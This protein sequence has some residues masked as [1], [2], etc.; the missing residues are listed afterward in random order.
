MIYFS[1]VTSSF[2]KSLKDE[3]AVFAPDARII[4]EWVNSILFESV[5]DSLV[6]KF[7][8]FA[9]VF[10][11][12]I[13][14][15]PYCSNLSQDAY[16]DSLHA[17]ANRIVFDRAGRTRLECINV[18]ASSDLSAK[19][20]EVALGMRMEGEGCNID[21]R[22]PELLVYLIIIGMRCYA[23][24]R[25]IISQADGFVDPYR[26][27][28]KTVEKSISRAEFKLAEAFDLFG[29][30]KGPGIAIDIGAAPGGWS[31][32]LSKRGFRVIAIDSGDLDSGALSSEG[33]A[34][35]SASEL[36][37]G[38]DAEV[39]EGITHIRKHAMEAEGTLRDGLS[40]DIITI[41]VNI[42]PEDAIGI[43]LRY[44]RFLKKKGIAVI[45][46]KCISRK[47]DRH[48][49][50]ASVRLCEEFE[51]LGKKV[52]PSNR[53]EVTFCVEKK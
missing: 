46:V 3:L 53:D 5:D 23:G 15:L 52:L 33:I 6:G 34:L 14:S 36:R 19:D 7:A 38:P 30:R 49:R 2:K 1:F 22:S 43:L 37:F 51:I 4:K 11:Y 20:I 41:D 17:A 27:Y 24:S 40:A 42:V 16:L 45:T 21:M 47:V 8:G 29:I 18:E 32:I 35:H 39:P 25:K 48:I 50:Y 12:S 26:Y 28:V 44:S 9:S 31:R 10:I 13:F